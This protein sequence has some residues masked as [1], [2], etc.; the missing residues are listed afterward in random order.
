MSYLYG[1]EIKFVYMRMH[2]Y[3]EREKMFPADLPDGESPPYQTIIL[4]LPPSPSFSFFTLYSPLSP[5][6]VSYL[7]LPLPLSFFSFRENS[8]DSF[9]SLPLLCRVSF[10]VGIMVPI[11]MEVAPLWWM[12]FAV[13]RSWRI[14]M[15]SLCLCGRTIAPRLQ[16]TWVHSSITSFV[17]APVNKYINHKPVLPFCCFVLMGS[18]LFL[19][20]CIPR[21]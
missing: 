16:P 2:I 8:S 6:S 9:P 10:S 7:S 20:E 14:E 19:S 18:L 17:V 15:S 21:N 5:A 11:L 1:Y 12:A 3:T 4:T 13:E